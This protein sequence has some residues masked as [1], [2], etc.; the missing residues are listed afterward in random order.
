MKVCVITGGG[1][2]MGLEAAKIIGK[3]KLIVISGRNLKKLED[4][5]KEL[6]KLGIKA[7]CISCDT[8][9]REDV[10]KLV[11]FSTKLGEVTTVI[12]SAGLSPVMSDPETIMKVNALGT[13]YVNQ[14][15]AN[16]LKKGSVIVDVASMAGYGLPEFIIPYKAYPYADKDEN[17]FLQ[18]VLKRASLAKKDP[19]QHAGFSYSISK[20]FV[21]WYAQK[22]A[23]DFAEK[24]IRVVSLSP[25]LIATG[26]GNAEKEKGLAASQLDTTCN[27]EMGTPESLG[28]ALA[29]VA[30]DRNT[31]LNAVDILVDG[32][33]TMGAKKF[34]NPK[35]RKKLKF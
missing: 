23:F 24:G 5:V 13:V 35:Y 20:N 3:E 17:K 7:K 29:S 28:Y 26:M 25:G 1:S 11:E 16:V 12:N 4:A 31:Y 18:I 27:H 33:C 2:G 8:S 22:S 10:V 9:K 14:E 34:R 19:Y 6:E 15:F 21:I 32:G 30:D